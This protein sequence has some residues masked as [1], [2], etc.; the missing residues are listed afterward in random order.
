MLQ[1]LT[2]LAEITG[3]DRETIKKR[4]SCLQPEPGPHGAKLF[5]SVK[6]LPLIYEM[7][8][9]SAAK[10]ENLRADT[11][12]KELKEQQLRGELAP[13]E[14]LTRALGLL[15]SQVSAILETIPGKLKRSL[16]QLTATD[17]DI[18][19]REIVKCL[20]ACADIALDQ[21]EVEDSADGKQS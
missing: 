20:N 11:R 8:E 21:I 4:L 18:A 7:D 3:K 17:L 2:F 10:T 19:K 5:D 16:P 13:V 15:A 14:E 9:L 6:A 1:S 12:L